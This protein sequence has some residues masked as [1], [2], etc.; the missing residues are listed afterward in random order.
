M[1]QA[2]FNSTIKDLSADYKES[3]KEIISDQDANKFKKIQENLQPIS[4]QI[5]WI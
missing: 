5:K 4:L 3:V 1:T 2:D